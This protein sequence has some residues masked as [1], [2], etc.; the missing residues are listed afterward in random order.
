M[1]K[2]LK[3]VFFFISDA[4]FV[5]NSDNFNLVLNENNCSRS[6]AISIIGISHKTSS[7][8]GLKYCTI[9]Q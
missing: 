4:T 3:F 9:V 1:F 5:F 6:D 8:T 2:N 7:E